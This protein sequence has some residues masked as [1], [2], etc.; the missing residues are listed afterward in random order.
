MWE[1]FMSSSCSV[2]SIQL[3]VLPIFTCQQG[4]MAVSAFPLQVY[5]LIVYSRFLQTDSSLS[6][7]QIS[8]TY[9]G[10][11]WSFT[12]CCFW[13]QEKLSAIY[14]LFVVRNKHQIEP[15]RVGA[16]VH[17]GCSPLLQQILFISYSPWEKSVGDGVFFFFFYKLV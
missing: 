14:Y 11:W 6:H 16:G 9:L 2:L 4:G 10:S 13:L 15:Y 12:T 1:G 7:L 8:K 3:F 17:A 5:L